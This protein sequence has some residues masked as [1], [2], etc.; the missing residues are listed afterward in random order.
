MLVSGRL[1]SGQWVMWRVGRRR[2][3]WRPRSVARFL[4]GADGP[5]FIA[6]AIALVAYLL[7]TWVGSLIATL[8]VWPMRVVRGMWPV[9]AYLLDPPTAMTDCGVSG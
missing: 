5:L 2:L 4:E 7:A 8:V 9:V 6:I 3:A 1:E